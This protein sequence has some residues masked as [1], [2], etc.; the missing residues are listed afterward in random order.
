M[1]DRFQELADEFG[2]ERS[3]VKR[4]LHALMYGKYNETS[5]HG[6]WVN[7]TAQYE[8]EKASK[9][10]TDALMACHVAT[11][12]LA[13]AAER[14]HMRFPDE[15]KD[16][17]VLKYRIGP[18]NSDLVNV[19]YRHGDRWRTTGVGPKLSTDWVW[20]DLARVIGRNDC[21]ILGVSEQV[22]QA[23]SV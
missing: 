8:Y 20:E 4:E 3:K 11:Q 13:K 21:W 10:Y 1:T 2:I 22:K 14:V 16:G 7:V 5:I 23:K 19:A 18:R 12:K 9:E 15:P 17:T 6:S